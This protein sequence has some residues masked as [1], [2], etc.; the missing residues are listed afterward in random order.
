M[1]RAKIAAG[2]Y[3]VFGVLWAIAVVV[4]ALALGWRFSGTGQLGFFFQSLAR[5]L[6]WPFD[7][8]SRVGVPLIAAFGAWAIAGAL[9]EYFWRAGGRG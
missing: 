8:E 5:V 1:R 2:T 4:F 9:V 7:L 6:T 3:V